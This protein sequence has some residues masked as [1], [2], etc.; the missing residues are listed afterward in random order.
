M[1]LQSTKQTHAQLT[2]HASRSRLGRYPPGVCVPRVRQVC[3]DGPA[4]SSP[5]GGRRLP[6]TSVS[7][8]GLYG[9]WRSA[10]GFGDR[11]L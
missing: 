7:R 4:A 8:T 5:R 9:Y 2:G 11:R 1:P 10:D 3:T 6:M